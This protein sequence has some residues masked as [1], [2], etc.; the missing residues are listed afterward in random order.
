MKGRAF[1]QV[2]AELGEKFHRFVDVLNDVRNHAGSASDSDILRQYDVWLK[3]GSERAERLLRNQG[4]HP[5]PINRSPW[6]H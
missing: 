3:T 2:F 1:G 5:L 6:E 4:V